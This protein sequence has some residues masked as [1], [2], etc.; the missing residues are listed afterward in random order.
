M[1]VTAKLLVSSELSLLK[2]YCSRFT[3]ISAP[4]WETWWYDGRSVDR[5]VD[6]INCCRASPAKWHDGHL[7]VTYIYRSRSWGSSI[8]IAAGWGLDD[9][10]VG[11]RVPAGSR[12]LICPQRPDRLLGPPSGY[13]GLFPRGQSG[14]GS[15][16]TTHPQPVPRTRRRWSIH[17]PPHTHSWRS[18]QLVNHRDNSTFPRFEHTTYRIQVAARR[19]FSAVFVSSVECD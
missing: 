1:H 9:R 6:W 3:V 13:Q 10:K 2:E 19:T 11:A 18:V 17:P 7:V 16:P 14:R 12:F 4:L 8:G 5:A 15:K